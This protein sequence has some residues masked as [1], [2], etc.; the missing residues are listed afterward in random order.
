MEQ[1]KTPNSQGNVKNKAGGNT[2]PNFKLSQNFSFV[3]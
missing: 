1:Q 3:I 2:L